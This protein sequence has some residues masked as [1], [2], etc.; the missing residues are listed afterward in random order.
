MRCSSS[1]NLTFACQSCV[2]Y[3]AAWETLESWQSRTLHT[4]SINLH[5]HPWYICKGPAQPCMEF[6]TYKV[7]SPDDSFI[8]IYSDYWHLD[9]IL[10]CSMYIYPCWTRLVHEGEFCH[11]F[12]WV[13]YKP[14]FEV[15]EWIASITGWSIISSWIFLNIPIS[16]YQKRTATHILLLSTN[17]GSCFVL[18]RFN[19]VYNSSILEWYAMS[20]ANIREDM[21]LHVTHCKNLK[22]CKYSICSVN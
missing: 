14:G 17:A 18:T 5:L 8:E 2:W 4:Y 15:A 20:T 3:Q 22:T 10:Q 19:T 16:I 12:G 7:K 11:P 6:F 1:K 13:T 9:T 21:D